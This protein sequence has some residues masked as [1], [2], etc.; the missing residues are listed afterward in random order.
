MY[1]MRL[2][3]VVAFVL[4]TAF[5]ATALSAPPEVQSGVKD[6]VKETLDKK[7]EDVKADG[8][9]LTFI[10]SA[11]FMFNSNQNV[12]GVQS[13][14]AI[15]LNTKIDLRMNL[16]KGPHEWRNGFLWMEGLSR[17]PS[18]DEFMLSSDDMTIN[19][20]Y[21]WHILDWVG[22]YG[23][24]VFDTAIFDGYDYQATP[25]AYSINGVVDPVLR[26]KYKLHNCFEPMTIK[27]GLGAF[28]RPVTSEAF[29]FE[30]LLGL[31]FR[32]AP[33]NNFLTN[34]DDPATKDM[35][36]LIS[37]GDFYQ[38]GGENI[39]RIWGDLW[40]KKINYVAGVELMMPL[41][42]HPDTTLSAADKLYVQ[43]GTRWAFRI[44]KWLSIDY[45]L[46][47]VRDKLMTA[48]WQIQNNI[49]I[50]LTYGIEKYIPG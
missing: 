1:K 6:A 27:E 48:D 15:T 10:P 7:K 18:I 8:W 43:M 21:L 45:E 25:T 19:S 16:V 37:V 33:R 50:N 46:K 17:T 44:V 32:E 5:G 36:E 41:Y 24:V 26:T 11:G 35:V 9:Y 49:M 22:L 42:D 34:K 14:Y 28:F 4:I 40:E 2:W 29:N 23:R 38:V 31:S 3:A 30:I 12:V 39:Y 47:V 20:I 13:G